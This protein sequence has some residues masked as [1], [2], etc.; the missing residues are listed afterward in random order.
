MRLLPQILGEHVVSATEVAE[1][2]LSAASPPAQPGIPSVGTV[3]T[4][5]WANGERH[6]WSALREP[7]CFNRR[8]G[9]IWGQCQALFTGCQRRGAGEGCL[10][11][12][13]D[14]VRNVHWTIPVGGGPGGG[15]KYGRCSDWLAQQGRE[16]W[17][18]PPQLEKARAR[19]GKQGEGGGGGGMG[20]PGGNWG[21]WGSGGA[22]G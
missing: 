22:E 8:G 14:R 16:F 21:N 17:A 4:Q 2:A 19:A 11:R 5:C 18:G 20:E 10:W 9:D 3:S 13:P 1:V 6:M 7:H 15:P 12:I